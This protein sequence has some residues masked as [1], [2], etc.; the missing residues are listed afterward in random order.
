MP[1]D[2]GDQRHVMIDDEDSQALRRDAL[3]QIVQAFFS[4]EFSPAAGS[5]SNSR[6]GLAASA[7]AISIRR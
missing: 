7:R 1:G 4:L 5:S 6:V 3:E 2:A